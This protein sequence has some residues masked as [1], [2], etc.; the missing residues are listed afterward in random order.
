MTNQT[1]GGLL[2][3]VFFQRK[4]TDTNNP[5]PITQ[6]T[7]GGIDENFFDIITMI[8]FIEHVR[9]PM[10]ILVKASRL[11][12]PGGRLVILTPNADSLSRRLMGLR[13]LHYKVEHLYYF[14]P[15]SLTRALRQVGLT[16]VRVGRA[17]KMMNLHYLAHQ[18]AQYPHRLLSPIV[19][20][21]HRLS[22]SS[23]R[24]GMFPISFGEL[25]A[26]AAKPPIGQGGND[27]PT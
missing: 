10:S 26:T 3:S 20:M 13:W 15:R 8:D 22:P 16:E 6:A 4:K 19:S 12:R 9:A 1:M 7:F 5:T 23:L 11:L 24:K 14:G 27:L 18:F 17:W 2:V 21:A 25:L